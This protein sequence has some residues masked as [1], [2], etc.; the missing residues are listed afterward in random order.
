MPPLCLLTM[1]LPIADFS[2]PEQVINRHCLRAS[3]RL[4][5]RHSLGF[6]AHRGLT[7][8]RSA[9]FPTF[10]PNT[11]MTRTGPLLFTFLHVF[12]QSHCPISSSGNVN[13][14]SCSLVL[15]YGPTMIHPTETTTFS[16]AV[17]PSLCLVCAASPSLCLL[18]TQW[19]FSGSL[20]NWN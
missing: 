16:A 4:F 6:V 15:L 9:L 18:R 11:Y 14:E 5:F 8:V 10:L 7:S 12:T 19:V 20:A 13:P 2:S 1:T 3:W 17:A